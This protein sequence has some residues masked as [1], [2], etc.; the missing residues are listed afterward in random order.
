ME[1][2]KHNL[3]FP[4]TIKIRNQWKRNIQ[5]PKNPRGSNDTNP[6]KI[7]FKECINNDAVSGVDDSEM[8]KAYEYYMHEISNTGAYDLG[9]KGPT[10]KK[11]HRLCEHMI[12]DTSHL[13]KRKSSVYSTTSGVSDRSGQ[14]ADTLLRQLQRERNTM[15]KL[16]FIEKAEQIDDEIK[17]LMKRA[18]D[19][20]KK[21]EGELLK[22][23]MIVHENKSTRRRQRLNS[24]LEVEMNNLLNKQ[25]TQ[26]ERLLNQQK[27]EFC[28]LIDNTQRR[29]IG[30]LK[31]C[32][33]KSW[34][35]C[36]H[37]KSASY[38]TRRPTPDIVI[39]K[40]NSSR[41][42]KNGQIDEAM[43]WEDKALEL[44]EE[45]QES[46]RQ[47]ISKSISVSPWGPNDSISDNLI[48]KHKHDIKVLKETHNIEV[49]VLNKKHERRK[50]VLNNII[51]S[52]CE[53]LKTQVHKEYLKMVEERNQ[54]EELQNHG[55]VVTMDDLGGIIVD[56][57]EPFSLHKK[58]FINNNEN[59]N[60][61][62][63]DSSNNYW[64]K[65]KE[66]TN[67]KESWIPPTHFG[68]EHS[69]KLM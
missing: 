63:D 58:V 43:I 28:K 13:R 25:I 57:D 40:R 37:N 53:R 26:C 18:L 32:N 50:Y 16:G 20:R 66:R 15:A 27:Q 54:L 42:K 3:Y 24:E 39:Y 69:E 12:Y 65:F 51:N 44:D 31:R 49:D 52:E 33:C 46:W 47:N 22:E 64:D 23:E 56:D 34:Y 62:Y 10:R 36:I 7:K 29:A 2:L 14:K 5:P 67:A 1:Y 11:L 9:P 59:N 41:L 17:S 19:E 68:L 21:E 30:K 8:D 38:N 48:Q 61:T 6:R 60:F 35:V 45:Q 55:N 4:P